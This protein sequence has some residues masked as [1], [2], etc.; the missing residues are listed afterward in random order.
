MRFTGQPEIFEQ[1]R[2]YLPYLAEE[3]GSSL[4]FLLTGPSG[5]GKTRLA[6]LCCNFLCPQQEFEL[7]VPDKKTGLVEINEEYR[8]HFID[9]VH[10]L[11][12]PEAL[13][14]TLDSGRFGQRMRLQTYRK[15]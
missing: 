2:I 1:L 5:V 14:H 8:V 4:N 13:Y 12:N 15:H 7:H 10:T 3:E 9:E 11:V 6:L